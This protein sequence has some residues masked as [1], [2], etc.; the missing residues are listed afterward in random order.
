MFITDKLKIKVRFLL[1]VA[2]GGSI[3][4]VLTP[5]G[6]PPNL[7]LLGFMDN[8]ESVSISF[9][10]W[11]FL[12]APFVVIMLLIMPYILSWG[13]GSEKLEQ[14][15]EVILFD[16]SQRKVAYILGALALLLIFNSP[17]KPY[18]NGLGLNEYMILTSFGFL[19]F[20]PKIELLTW[21]DV[22]SFPLEI[23]FLFGAGFTIAMAFIET[24]LAIEVTNYLTHF[25]NLSLIMIFILVTVFV[26]F[27]T[28]VT[29]NTALTSIAIPIFFEFSKTL[30]LN[31]TLIM[32]LATVSASCAFMLPIA[33]PPNAIIMSSRI[34]K[35]KDM[36]SFG[37][38]V[39]IIAIS[40]LTLVAY[41]YWSNTL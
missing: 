11:I 4:G 32:L 29:S 8:I 14:S 7:I 22:R 35:V 24:K 28:E 38:V 30:E 34:I 31:S 5:I 19:L 33:T 21:D 41:F 12:T 20:M 17:I 13:L 18:Y 16:K 15:N 25:S 2:Y 26:S 1:A 27:L 3:G 37:F 6:T 36:L 23:L 39:H 10:G 9:I 40:V